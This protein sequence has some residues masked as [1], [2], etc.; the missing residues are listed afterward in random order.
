MHGGEV[1]VSA[2]RDDEKFKQEPAYDL[3]RRIFGAVRGFL[4]DSGIR[5]ETS[6]GSAAL[7]S[8]PNSWPALELPG[9]RVSR[10]EA[11]VNGLL[12]VWVAPIGVWLLQFVS[13][14]A[15]WWWSIMCFRNSVS[16]AAPVVWSSRII[17]CRS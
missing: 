6:R 15:L 16:K 8:V 7:K 17:C 11:P 5:D 13:T 9:S 10:I 14:T 2:L 4:E 12:N 1:R 3:D